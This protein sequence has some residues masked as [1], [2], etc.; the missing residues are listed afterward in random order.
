MMQVTVSRVQVAEDLRK[1]EK[2]LLPVFAN[3]LSTEQNCPAGN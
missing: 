3:V 1:E 2:K